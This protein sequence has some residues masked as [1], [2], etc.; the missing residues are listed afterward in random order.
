VTRASRHLLVGFAITLVVAGIA[1]GLVI[2]GPPGEE[3][4][5]RLDQKR[6]ADLVAIQ[7]AVGSYRSRHGRLPMSL[8]TIEREDGIGIAVADPETRSIY[9][10]RPVDDRTFETCAVFDRESPAPN[11]P[12]SHGAGRR[13]FRQTLADPR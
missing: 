5:T 11:D 3:R 1:G 13:C 10:Y 8:D 4:I 7:S 12:M 9:E 6:V 2:L